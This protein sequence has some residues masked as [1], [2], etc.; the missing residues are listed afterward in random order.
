M[1][2]IRPPPFKRLDAPLPGSQVPSFR[3][4]TST[5]HLHLG[6]TRAAIATDE[7]GLLD[8]ARSAKATTPNKAEA[9]AVEPATP[10]PLPGVGIRI[11]SRAKHGAGSAIPLEARATDE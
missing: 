10:A 2:A 6:R 11:R 7:R 5:C 9:S 3:A 1:I 4:R 8:E